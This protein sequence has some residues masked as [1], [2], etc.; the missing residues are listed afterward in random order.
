MSD[1]FI[2]IQNSAGKVEAIPVNLIKYVTNDVVIYENFQEQHASNSP[3]NEIKIN[4]TNEEVDAL[5]NR[6]NTL[7]Y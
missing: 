2:P 3:H 7:S 5:I 4:L 1:K 6:I